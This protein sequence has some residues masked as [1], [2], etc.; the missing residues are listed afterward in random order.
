MKFLNEVKI[1]FYVLNLFFKY[2]F[3]LLFFA[4]D[5]LLKRYIIKYK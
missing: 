3:G 5:K 2:K 1:N 4:K